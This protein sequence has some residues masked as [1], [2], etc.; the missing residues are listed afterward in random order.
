MTMA[1]EDLD[2]MGS[3]RADLEGSALADW[4][5]HPLARELPGDVFLLGH[6]RAQPAFVAGDGTTRGESPR[7]QRRHHAPRTRQEGPLQR[8]AVLDKYRIEE[9]IGSGGFAF[10][11]RATHLLLRIPV[12][13]KL[14][15]PEQ[16]EQRDAAERL[17]EEARCAARIN[18]PNVVRIHDVTH[19]PQITYIVMEYIEGRSLARAIRAAGPLPPHA[20]VR[21]GLDVIAGLRAGLQEGL[22][23]RDIKPANILLSRGGGARIVDFGLARTT[24]SGTSERTLVGTR[25]YVAPEVV[26][27]QGGDFRADIFS[28]GVTLYEAAAGARPLL[29]YGAAQA[30]PPPDLPPDLPRRLSEALRWMLMPRRE[31]RPASYDQI[32]HALRN[33]LTDHG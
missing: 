28:L 18:H 16:L 23:H 17:V 6:H 29:P 20:V 4:T 9:L 21:L 32:E 12:A 26:E 3:F 1:L 11:Y 19:A 30:W 5:Q 25:G 15:R 24:A 31:D 8:L 14:L 22:I 27:G 33:A 7:A 13:I 10:V 2:L